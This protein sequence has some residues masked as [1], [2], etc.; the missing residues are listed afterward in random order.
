[1]FTVTDLHEQ[2]I[3]RYKAKHHYED[4]LEAW[5]DFYTGV[6]N[7]EVVSIPGI[8][9]CFY[10]DSNTNVVRDSY[11]YV[12]DGDVWFVFKVVDFTGAERWFK[13]AGYADSYSGFHWDGPT[14]EV[15]PAKVEVTEWKVVG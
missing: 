5:N 3:A 1:M 13:R 15:T 2:V 11:G 9:H 10:V 12:L 14:Y 6:L 7:Q 8:G 4:T